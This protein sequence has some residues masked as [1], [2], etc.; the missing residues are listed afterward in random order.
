MASERASVDYYFSFISLWSYVGSAVFRAV[1]A[2][3]DARVVFKPV[4]LLAVF[5]AGGGKPVRERALPR[6][7]YRLVEM[8]R[9]SAIRDIPLVTWPK[10]YPADPSLGHRMLL[11]AIA[12]GDDVDA[13][14]HACLKAVWADELDIA[15]AE[16]LVGLADASGLDGRALLDRQGDPALA[17]R[18]RR[19]TREAIDRQVFG[20]PFYVFRGEP[21]WGQDRLEMLDDVMSANR[22]PILSSEGRHD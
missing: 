9:W 21:F 11:A 4:D 14:V 20:A 5:A 12:R 19:L 7:A 1:I 3:H 8:Q 6:Q 13:F 10:F 15:D 16:T 2:R 22:P 18:E 17:E